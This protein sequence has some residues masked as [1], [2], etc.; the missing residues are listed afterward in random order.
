MTAVAPVARCIIAT[1]DFASARREPVVA[2]DRNAGTLAVVACVFAP[3]ALAV[4]FGRRVAAIEIPPVGQRAGCG[5]IMSP[6]V[7][8]RER[9][10]GPECQP[11]GATTCRASG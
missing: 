10:D 5:G 4:F 9:Q 3:L 1:S 11:G 7:D 8:V 6:P 2:L